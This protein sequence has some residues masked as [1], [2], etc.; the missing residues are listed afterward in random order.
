VDLH[1]LRSFL[2]DLRTRGIQPSTLKGYFA[3][4]SALYDYLVFE[5]L[6]NTNPIPSFRKRY[7]SRLKDQYGGE[8]SR[9]L[10][11]VQDMQLLVSAA[12]SIHDQA[13]MMTLAKTGM[14]R[15]E[16]HGLRLEDIDIKRSI[17]RIP[18]KAKRSNRL[19]FMDIE[20]QEVLAQYLSWRKSRARTDW[21]WITK[22]GGRIHKD[23]PGRILGKLGAQLGL[24]D[25]AGPL[26]SK[27]TPHCCRHWF[28][29]HLHRAGMNPEYIKWLRGDSLRSEAW[30]IYNHIDPDD[31]LDEY[32][33]CMPR[34]LHQ[35]TTA[36]K[37]N[38]G[39][40]TDLNPR[41]GNEGMGDRARKCTTFTG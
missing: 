28:T 30:Q 22:H 7:L 27:L 32:L 39:S 5:G 29:T 21:F 37:E 17:I 4:L 18:A 6:H 12:G 24:H 31:V 14:R 11:S 20:L 26:C 1:D 25:P 8:N 41:S 23:Y 13:L 34:L 40:N 16:L 2:G 38:K 33:L 3:A 35:Q 10:I 19:A 15:G 9:Q 36:Y